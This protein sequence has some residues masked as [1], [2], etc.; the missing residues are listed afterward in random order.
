MKNV[1]IISSTR[2]SDDETKSLAS[3][4]FQT[5]DYLDIAIYS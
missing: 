4:K 5:G 1:G 3:L 2:K